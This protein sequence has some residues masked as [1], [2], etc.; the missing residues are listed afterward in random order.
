MALFIPDSIADLTTRLHSDLTDKGSN[1]HSVID[2]H[3]GS[4]SN[5]H[6]V[7]AAQAGALALSLAD[8]KGDIFVATANDTII[9]L[10]IGT[11]THAL[12][13]DSGEASGVKWAAVAGSSPLTTKGDLYTYSTVDARLPIGTN[14]YVLLPDSG[15]ATGLKWAAELPD[16][17]LSSNVP[18]IKVSPLRQAKGCSRCTCNSPLKRA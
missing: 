13:A 4:S 9:R 8:A 14:D 7:T 17:R 6:S 5:P 15:E 2:T 11:N 1:A 10:P 16:A 3:L 12:I 18:L